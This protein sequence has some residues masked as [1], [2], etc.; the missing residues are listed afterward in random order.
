MKERKVAN[1]VYA[2]IDFVP[3]CLMCS[4]SDERWRRGKFVCK[5]YPKGISETILMND[6][7][8]HKGK[9]KNPDFKDLF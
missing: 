3:Q 1:G 2:H 6:K 7:R 8:C 4:Y 5:K 9:P